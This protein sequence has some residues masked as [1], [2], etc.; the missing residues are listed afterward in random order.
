MNDIIK[1]YLRAVR[2]Q[3]PHLG[4][5]ERDAVM[6]EIETHLQAEV[7]RLRRLEKGLSADEAA[8]RATNAFGDPAEIGIAYGDRGGVINR[9]T[10][11]LLLEVAVLTTRAAGRGVRSIAKWTGITALIIVGVGLVLTVAVLYLANDFLETYQDDIRSNVPRPLYDYNDHWDVTEAH[12]EITTSTFRMPDD[13]NAFWF[14]LQ[15]SPGSDPHGCVRVTL[16]DPDGQ[17]A[18]DSGTGCGRIDH[19]ATLTQQGT[20]KITYQFAAF[21]GSVAA[22][23]YYFTSSA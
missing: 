11:E 22:R 6:Q 4:V 13:A 1:D 20:W 3:L 23:A 8:L 16:V 18:Y 5:R 21:H 9:S 17:V 15:V 14:H 12:T 10:G 19:T 7:R 2:R